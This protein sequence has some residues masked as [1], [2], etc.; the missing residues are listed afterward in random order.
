MSE[1]EHVYFVAVDKLG[2]GRAP[3][4]SSWDSD[5]SPSPLLT[6]RQLVR[7]LQQAGVLTA[8]MGVPELSQWA[9][10]QGQ[11]QS[12]VS[13]ALNREVPLHVLCSCSSLVL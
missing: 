3:H 9:V 1:L 2:S 13:L 11:G 7:M 12:E 5:P 6:V 8:D 10:P 4:S